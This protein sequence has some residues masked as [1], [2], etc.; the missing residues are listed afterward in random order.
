MV[1]A[2][3]S[4]TQ[5][6]CALGFSVIKTKTTEALGEINKIFDMNSTQPQGQAT[7]TDSILVEGGGHFEDCIIQIVITIFPYKPEFDIIS[8]KVA[9]VGKV[10]LRCQQGQDIGGGDILRDAFKL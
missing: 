2:T 5:R 3:V 10:I 7:L 8:S 1:L 4:T 9:Q 6:V